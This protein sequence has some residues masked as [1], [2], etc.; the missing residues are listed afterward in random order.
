MQ[1]GVGNIISR[2]GRQREWPATITAITTRPRLLLPGD[3]GPPQR[4]I[5]QPEHT[6]HT[7]ECA[8]N[9]P[10]EHSEGSLR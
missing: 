9:Y 5:C 8:Q 3:L 1:R 7:G 10:L 2:H 6:R 4:N